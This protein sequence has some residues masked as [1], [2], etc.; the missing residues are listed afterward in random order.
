ME[1]TDK[2][3]EEYLKTVDSKRL[4]DLLTLIDLATYITQKPPKM[5]GSIIGFGSLHYTYKSGRQGDMPLFGIANRKQAITLY[6]SY[7]L[8]KYAQLGELGK[9]KMGVGCLYIKKLE[10]IHL[11]VLHSLIKEAI[12]DTLLSPI[13]QDNE[14]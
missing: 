4:P 10:D 8:E 9:F 14:A 12:N 13:I 5:W 2:T 7:T 3:V 11:P 6:V 1:M